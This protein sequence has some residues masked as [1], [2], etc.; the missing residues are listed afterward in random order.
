V[1]AGYPIHAA[2][3]AATV[4]MGTHRLDA[5]TIAAVHVGMPANSLRVVDNRA[6]HSICVQDMLAAAIVR[7]GLRLRDSL[8]PAILDHP[9]FRAI[10]GRITVGVDP[11]LQRDQPDGRGANVA[12]TTTSGSVLAHRVD[13]PR[14]HSRRGGVTWDDLSAKWHD[15]LPAHAI[16]RA[17][18]LAQHLDE[19]DDAREL[20]DLYGAIP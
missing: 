4:V 3:E 13:W 12:I 11:D 18:E 19:L 7:G 17:L 8:F 1:N 2:I 10:R 6:M 15:A 16:D 20:A 5:S 14:G 9:D